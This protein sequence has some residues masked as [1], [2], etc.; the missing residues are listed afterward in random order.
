MSE[1]GFGTWERCNGDVLYLAFLMKLS[2]IL[3]ESALVA[4][5]VRAANNINMSFKL[6]RDEKEKLATAYQL[7]ESEEANA[8]LLG[9]SLL[10]RARELSGLQESTHR[11]PNPIPH[12]FLPSPH[13]HSS[14]RSHPCC[15]TLSLNRPP[16]PTPSSLSAQLRRR[17]NHNPLCYGP[18]TCKPQTFYMA[19]YPAR[20][21]P[22]WYGF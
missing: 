12:P 13:P 18:R 17:T 8:D 4:K 1:E 11:P 7:R 16:Y 6:K 22:F 9:H 10:A 5:W 3:S 21:K 19:S 14:P 15:P 2:L 20:H